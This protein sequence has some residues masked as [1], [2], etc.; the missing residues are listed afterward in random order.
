MSKKNSYLGKVLRHKTYG[1]CLVV[2]VLDNGTKLEC[3]ILETKNRKL[4]VL[5]LRFFDG[6][7]EDYYLDNQINTNYYHSQQRLLN[8]SLSKPVV[9]RYSRSKPQYKH[10]HYDDQEYMGEDQTLATF[11]QE[12]YYDGE[13]M[14]D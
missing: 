1:E 6:V 8:G 3:E 4:F 12:A 11:N 14:G 7:T 10:S 2:K 9:N 5:S 13:D